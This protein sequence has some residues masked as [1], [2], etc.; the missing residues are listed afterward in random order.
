MATM[1]RMTAVRLFLT[2]GWLP[3]LL[4]K[5]LLKERRYVSVCWASKMRGVPRTYWISASPRI[6]DGSGEQF[7]ISG[8]IKFMG[9]FPDGE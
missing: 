5:C 2:M 4:R 3:N 6:S 1:T 8:P 9:I 7:V